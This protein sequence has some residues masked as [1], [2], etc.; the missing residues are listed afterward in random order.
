MKEKLSQVLPEVSLTC[1]QKRNCKFTT[2]PAVQTAEYTLPDGTKIKV[3]EER[4][5]CYEPLFQTNLGVPFNEKTV[6][7][8][9]C[10]FCKSHFQMVFEALS[11]CA[12]DLRTQLSDFV[13]LSGGTARAKGFKE[14]FV[15]EMKQ[16]SPTKIKVRDNDCTEM[17]WVGGSILASLN[18]FQQ[19]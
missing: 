17:A 1:A 13:V 15:N 9:R 16:L 5:L 3:N 14:R 12:I 7:Q 2:C 10:K 18:T 11:S 19:M 6:P 8:V 4:A